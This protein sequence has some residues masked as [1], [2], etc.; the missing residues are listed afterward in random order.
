MTITAAA[1][2]M[3]RDWL[4]RAE[5]RSPVVCLVQGCDTPPEITEALKHGAKGRELERI[6]SAALATVPKY[7]YPAVYPR[8]HFLWL[9]AKIGEFRFAPLFAHPS[10][11]RRAMKRGVLD[12]AEKGLVLRDA[13]GTI[14]LPSQATT[15][16]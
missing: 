9:F 12:V 16:L 5:V 11:A 8:S 15:A 13:D 3:I 6:S 2:D 1:S 4:R 10:V 7:L 14:V